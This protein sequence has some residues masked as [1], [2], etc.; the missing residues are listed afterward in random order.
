[1]KH[2]FEY[3]K[4]LVNYVKKNIKKGYTTESLKWALINQDHSKIKV[5]KA[6]ETAHEELAKEAPILKSRPTI[7]HEVI[8]P[9]N[10]KI[11][12]HEPTKKESFW[13]KLFKN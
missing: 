3:N 8:I 7:K 11:Q 9:K 6:I 4:K 13:S 1:M 10:K 12:F 2:D 5:E